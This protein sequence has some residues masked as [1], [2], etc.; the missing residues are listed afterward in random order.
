MPEHSIDLIPNLI[1][2]HKRDG[3]CVYNKAAK[4]EL[5]SRCLE[6]GVSLARLAMAHGVNANLLRKWVMKQAGANPS[7]RRKPA[8]AV[9]PSVSLMPVKMVKPEPVM[10]PPR[11][12]GYL[13][14]TVAGVTIRVQGEINAASLSVVLDCLAKHA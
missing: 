8:V 13:E 6:P 1:K 9:V 7:R 5:V 4:R 2:G 14:F 10:T 11:P 3:R 12:E